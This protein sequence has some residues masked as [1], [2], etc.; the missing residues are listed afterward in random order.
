LPGFRP[1]FFVST[2]TAPA[3]SGTAA[4]AG[5]ARLGAAPGAGADLPGAT[6]DTA[7]AY[8]DGFG[9]GAESGA[10][11]LG[12]E[13]TLSDTDSHHALRVLRL[14]VGDECEVVVGAAV[15]AASVVAAVH[16]VRVKLTTRLAGAAA[17]AR[18]RI[19]VGL[20]Q[21]LARPAALDYVVE[22]GTEVGVSFFLLV[23]ASG[24][25]KGSDLSR[26]G[27]LTRWR[28]IAEEAAKQSKQV[29]VP[30]VELAG[31]VAEALDRLGGASG[32]ANS[33]APGGAGVL[34]GPPGA[35]PSDAGAADRTPS[36]Q[37]PGAVLSLALDPGAAEGLAETLARRRS[38][39][40]QAPECVA[41]QPVGAERVALWVGPE[42]G[43]SV[44]ERAQFTAAGIAGV[45]LGR[46]VLRTETAGP[47]GVAVAR[48][49]LGDW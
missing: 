14:A 17:G 24:S 35:G 34:D 15:Y 31:S 27:R 38:E 39:V 28:R 26:E 11:L 41:S 36:A 45:R 4:G 3:L 48:L 20:V 10:D 42:G 44:A 12:T 25:P 30:E 23:P 6:P 1:R 49:A 18:Y 21:A 5:G 22:K 16:P 37:S 33:G 29:V 46:G 7:D 9:A 8:P 19:Q 13:V 40:S 47:V 32:G 2:Q 43:W